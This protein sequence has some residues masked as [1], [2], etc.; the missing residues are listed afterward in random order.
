MKSDL[1]RD[2]IE[3]RIERG[4]HSSA[5]HAAM[6]TKV[7]FLSNNIRKAENA[8]DELDNTGDLELH[9]LLSKIMEK[10]IVEKAKR[11]YESIIRSN[12]TKV[13]REAR[14]ELME[15]D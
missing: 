2:V 3:K 6:K 4:A 9:E 10:I 14:K 13:V 15:S 5:K 8:H 7:K 11:K 12:Y 1:I